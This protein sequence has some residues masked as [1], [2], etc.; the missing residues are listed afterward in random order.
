MSKKYICPSILAADFKNLERDIKLTEDGGADIIHCDIMDGQFVPNISFGPEIVH[1]V[2]QITGL[3]L[4]VHLM[5]NNPE[6]F[7]DKF[8]KAG[9][10]YISVHYE[11]NNH[12]NRLIHQIKDAG[13]KAGVVLNPATPFFMLDEL[14]S[15]VDFILVMSVNPGFGGQK[16]IEQSSYKIKHIKNRLNEVHSKALIEVDGGIGPENI[17]MISDCGVDMFVCGASIFK[18]KDIK[19]TTSELKALVR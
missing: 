18:S 12:V 8:A 6:N 16:Y 9:A 15:I 7:I 1:Q 11:N 14:Y 4:D 19:K 5:I 2:S 10:D 17:K 3:P 13:C